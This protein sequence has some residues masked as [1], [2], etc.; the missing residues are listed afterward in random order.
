MLYM[1][2]Q[3]KIFIIYSSLVSVVW[4]LETVIK[5]LTLV[6]IVCILSIVPTFI[7]SLL[8]IGCSSKKAQPVIG[9]EGEGKKDESAVHQQ[10]TPAAVP[11]STPAEKKPSEKKA[12]KEI[13]PK[14]ETDGAAAG[15][16]GSGDGEDGGYEACP[17]MTP[18]QLA[19]IA[20]ES[21]PK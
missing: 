5:M 10:S 7:F 15:G 9:K 13:E 20:N 6:T 17:D 4:W 2:L 14:K 8:I 12:S 19:K 3:N 11:S 16:G 1:E 18:E 21:P